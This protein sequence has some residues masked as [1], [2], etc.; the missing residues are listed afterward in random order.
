MKKN[1]FGVFL[2]IFLISYYFFFNHL[3]G[4]FEPSK[5]LLVENFDGDSIYLL[6]TKRINTSY[7]S[8]NLE[9]HI[10][11]EAKIILQ[12]A[13]GQSLYQFSLEKG[14]VT[15]TFHGEWYNDTLRL[16]CMPK[17]NMTGKIKVTYKFQ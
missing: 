13:A 3:F 12:T 2:I 14:N 11:K 4:C 7:L 10:A 17:E 15:K 1:V 8:L 6:T 9:G 16:V 5:K